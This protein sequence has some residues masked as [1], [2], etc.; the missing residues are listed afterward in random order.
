MT[1]PG[2][3]PIR[4]KFPARVIC[5]SSQFREFSPSDWR[6]SSIPGVVERRK[7]DGFGV[8]PANV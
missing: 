2:R 1:M 8:F 7:I 3:R 5:T 4:K 6:Y